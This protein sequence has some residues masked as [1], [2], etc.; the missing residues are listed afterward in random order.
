MLAIYAEHDDY[1]GPPVREQLRGA[2][3]KHGKPH[4]IRVYDGTAH[5]FFND[6]RAEVH[7]AE[8]SKDAWERVLTLFRENL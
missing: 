1:F 4:E 8:A 2:L 3:E 7:N 5:G 6:T